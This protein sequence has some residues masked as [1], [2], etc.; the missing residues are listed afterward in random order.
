MMRL[1]R[2]LVLVIFSLA[3]VPAATAFAADRYVALGDSYSSGT[4]TRDYSLS[5]QCER[6][7]ASYPALIGRDRPNTELVFP[8]CGGAETSD[9]L[10]K[11]VNSL[12]GD[13]QMVSISIG[14]NDAGFGAV[15]KQCAKPWPTTCWGDINKAQA[16]IRDEL[17]G[18]LDGVYDQITQRSPGAR[19]A[20]VGYPHLFDGNGECSAARISKG[21]QDR[22]NE[23]ADNMA[24]TLAAR[25]RAHGFRFVDARDAFTGHAVCDRD[26]WL[27][28]LSSPVGD[29]FHPNVAGHRAYENLV[30]PAIG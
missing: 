7:P 11:Q 26:E 12:T 18:R 1:T 14:G 9:V 5:S 20:V 4:G 23:A 27:N 30:R 3:L 13:T 10:A 8:A 21:E 2:V 15:V 24:D 28:G 6:S 19:V 17:P 25:A 16:F 22:L 29:S